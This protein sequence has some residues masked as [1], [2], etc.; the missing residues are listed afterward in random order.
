METILTINDINCFQSC[1]L[2]FQDLKLNDTTTDE[3]IFYLIKKKIQEDDKDD[4]I[5]K[6]LENYSNNYRA[7][8]EFDENFDENNSITKKIEENINSGKYYF[9][10]LSDEYKINNEL[11][12]NG[13]DYLYDLKCKINVKGDEKN[14]EKLKE[15]NKKFEYFENVV[16]KINTIKYYINY[17]RNKGSQIELLIEVHFCYDTD[18]DYDT[19]KFILGNEE[20]TFNEI[21][22]YLIKV[23]KYY[24]KL[25][26]RFYL[27]DEC[28]RFAYGKQFN[29]IVNYL[30][31]NNNDNSFTI[32]FLNKIPKKE[33][34]RSFPLETS[35]SIKFYDTYLK[36][37]LRNISNY[38]Q[39]Y[40]KDNYN[41]LENFYNEYKVI[42]EEKGI[43]YY[44]NSEESSIEKKAID[45][46]IEF[47]DKYPLS[48]NILLI[49][50]NTSPEE[51]ESFLY[52]SILCKYHS[53][54]IIGINDILASQEDFL[55][56]KVNFLIKYIK[57]RDNPNSTNKRRIEA[58]IK[59]CIIF[60]YNKN[61]SQNKFIEQIKKIASYKNLSRK[62]KKENENN[63]PVNDIKF[64]QRQSTIGSISSSYLTT[65][66]KIEKKN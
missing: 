38:I 31:A 10:K 8:K 21:K 2:F 23:K 45:L 34:Y 42:K 27:N 33:L 55:M 6:Y 53:L 65:Q 19:G 50:R 24:M 47:T 20:K 44:F 1:I 59:P 39:N 5:L 58:D 28:I 25:L 26:T 62:K 22:L 35:D 9:Y 30:N 12:K 14:D 41:S 16:D 3:E 56:K 61:I 15:K 48:Q 63:N 49:N 18:K 43:Y 51:L 13:F 57:K 40:F 66:D 17:L 29:F 52:R 36:N 32:Y 64:V 7:I 54:F 4:S 11:I 46:F 60:I 37:I